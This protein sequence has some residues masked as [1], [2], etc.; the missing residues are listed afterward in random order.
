MK[1]TN[2][3][4]S[5]LTVT[6]LHIRDSVNKLTTRFPSSKAE[7]QNRQSE[8]MKETTLIAQEGQL[9]AFS[10]KEMEKQNTQVRTE[11]KPSNPKPLKMKNK[12]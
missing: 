9:T 1:S 10:E 4:S 12:P 7:N 2:H 5:P 3:S 6:Y 11:E 8:R